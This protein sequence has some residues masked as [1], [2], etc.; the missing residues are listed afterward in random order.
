ML[1]PLRNWNG[2]GTRSRVG[3]CYGLENKLEK[4]SR[5]PRIGFGS[6]ALEPMR[7][8]TYRTVLSL[9]RRLTWEEKCAF[10]LSRDERH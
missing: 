8:H 3:N 5:W 2:R 7:T 6:A 1:S 9:I 4:V 10:Q